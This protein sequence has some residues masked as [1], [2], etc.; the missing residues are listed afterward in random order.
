MLVGV[1]IDSSS[2]FTLLI[3]AVTTLFFLDSIP[4]YDNLVKHGGVFVQN[5]VEF[6]VGTYTGP[7]GLVSYAGDDQMLIRIIN[8]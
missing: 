5:N 7:A 2:P 6:P 1:T 8:I 3:A 4:Y